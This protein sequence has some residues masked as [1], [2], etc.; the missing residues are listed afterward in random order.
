MPICVL[1]PPLLAPLLNDG[2]G[3]AMKEDP[4]AWSTTTHVEDPDEAPGSW[5]EP[6]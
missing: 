2:L 3:K 5:F 6:M 4:S 1:D